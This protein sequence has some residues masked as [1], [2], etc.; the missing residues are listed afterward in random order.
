MK[1]EDRVGNW[2]A[3]SLGGDGREWN[4]RGCESIGSMGGYGRGWDGM[5]M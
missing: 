4:G 2:R 5:G 3:W 1:M